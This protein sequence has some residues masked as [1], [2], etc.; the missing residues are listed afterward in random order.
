MLIRFVIWANPSVAWNFQWLTFGITDLVRVA[1]IVLE[2][3]SPTGRVVFPAMLAVF[4]I[5]QAP[6]LLG[7]W[8]SA[9]WQDFARWCAALPLT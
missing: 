2:R 5:L 7:L 6:A 4:A 3:R 9:T 8:K 1:L